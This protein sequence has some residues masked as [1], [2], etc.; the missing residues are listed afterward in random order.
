MLPINQTSP[1]FGWMIVSGGTV[2][3]GVGVGVGEGVGYC[4]QYLPVFK[5]PAPKSPSPPQ[6]IISLPV[7]TAV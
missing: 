3:V 5:Y 2:G 1:Q 4:P 7:Q 6:M